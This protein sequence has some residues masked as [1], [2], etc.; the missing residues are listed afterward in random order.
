MNQYIAQ[1]IAD[2][3]NLSFEQGKYIDPLKLSNTIPIF[4]KKGS[5]L[6]V[7]NYRPISLLSNI[8]KIFEKIMYTRIYDFLNMNKCLYKNQFGF[9]KNHSTIHA[10]IDLTEDIREALDKNE[11]AVGIFIDLQKAFDT[12]DHIILLKKLDHYGIRGVANLWFQSYLTNRLQFVSINGFTSDTILMPIGVPQGSILGPLL[13][14]IYINDFHQSISFSNPRHF[15]DDTNLL[16]RDKSLKK[17]RKKLNLD[18]R[19]V[20]RWLRANKI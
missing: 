7:S 4:K 3:V 1:P 19:F 5:E 16:I 15:A 12:V 13:F 14:L 11:F 6:E 9:R 8:N 20:S 18:L 10:L 2:L 17:I